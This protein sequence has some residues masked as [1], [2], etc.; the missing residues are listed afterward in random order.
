MRKKVI[1]NL[2]VLFTTFK[3]ENGGRTNMFV[4][5]F[6]FLFLPQLHP[7]DYLLRGTHFHSYNEALFHYLQIPRLRS[8]AVDVLSP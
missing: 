5:V 7:G 2:E 3:E 6:Y 4:C 8:A 1:S